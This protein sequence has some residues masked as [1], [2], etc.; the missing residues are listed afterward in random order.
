MK[1][2]DR[3]SV[4]GHA[5]LSPAHQE[6]GV[7]ILTLR[8]L[9]K[10]VGQRERLSE[11]LHTELTLEVMAVDQLPLARYLSPK[12]CHP[13]RGKLGSAGLAGDALPSSEVFTANGSVVHFFVPRTM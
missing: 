7:V 5:E 6:V 4:Q 11:V 13:L 2:V 1:T 10:L 8:D 12:A 3:V 9:A